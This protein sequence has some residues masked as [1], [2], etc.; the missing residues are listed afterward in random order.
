MGAEVGRN[1]LHRPFRPQPVGHL[2]QPDLGLEVQA[3]AGLGL[4]R[5]HAVAE[6]LVQPAAAVGEQVVGGGRPGRGDRR[7]DPAAGG[8]DLEV[9]GA[10]LAQEHLALARAGE[11]QMGVRIDQARA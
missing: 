3:V 6:H 2:D 9:A 10:A 5:R 11:Q 4:D 8:Q 1:D 7:Q